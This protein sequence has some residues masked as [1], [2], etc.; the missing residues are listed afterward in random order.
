MSGNRINDQQVHLY[1]T[2]RKHHSQEIAAAKAGISVRTARRIET[3]VTLP[4]Q[5]LRRY[6]RSRPDPFVDVW[7][8]I[9]VPLLRQAPQLMGVTLLRKLQEDHPDQFPGGMLRTL[10]RRV[11]HW[12]ALEGP[13]KE[14]FFPQEHS[15]GA[16]GLSDFTNMNALGITVAGM[17][18]DHLLYHFV[19]AFSRWEY[20]CVV[21]TGESFEALS[22]GLQN[23]LWQ[24][25]GCPKEHRSD[26]LSAAFKNLKQ[27]D[28]FTVRYAA[29]LAHYG[30]E[31]TRNN[32]GL[33]HEN[34]SV[35][36]S[37]RFLK[38]AISQALLL[39]GYRDFANRGDY[40]AFVRDAV[41]RRNRRHAAA[42]RIEREQLADLPP[43]RTTDF[44]E[45]EA[46][47]TR[48]GKFT[49]RT[50]LYSAPSRLIGHQLKVRLYSDRLECYLAAALVLTLP[51]GT[52]SGE[53]RIIDYRHFIEALKCKP[54]AFKGL[55]F[56]DTLFPREAYRRTWEALDCQLSQRLVCH[57]MVG[58][59]ELA[60]MDGIEAVLA[61][62]LDAL[63]TSNQLP[64][65][66]AL[67][68]EF[69]PRDQ[70]CPTVRIDMPP[71]SAYDTLLDEPMLA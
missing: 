29:L 12:R 58:L 27:E 17:P 32:R 26:S 4:S 15:P 42:F 44:T 71:V 68:D 30:M 49:V 21:D 38:E 19:L 36:S 25:G 6:W 11:S 61:E 3:D 10:Q 8:S 48:C 67:R 2:K 55:V 60:G 34:G 23:A 66:K 45:D 63:R 50:V 65:L 43:Q 35:E 54:Q 24:A 33:G 40:D 37:H 20:A 41:M 28:D 70:L 57:T 69:A 31:G 64:D 1:M 59:L 39:R 51:R 47:V 9:V 14:V 7:D 22:A 13:T 62:R 5:K 46:R 18:F 52:R 56:R 53:R 16:R